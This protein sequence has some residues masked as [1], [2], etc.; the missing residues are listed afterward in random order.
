MGRAKNSPTQV[1]RRGMTVYANLAD[2]V[3]TDGQDGRSGRW[4]RRSSNPGRSTPYSVGTC[5]MYG[6]RSTSYRDPQQHG[7]SKSKSRL[8]ARPHVGGASLNLR[9]SGDV[10][11]RDNSRRQLKS[12]PPSLSASHA[13][14]RRLFF[15]T[16]CSAIRSTP[17]L[18]NYGVLL[19]TEYCLSAGISVRN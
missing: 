9:R 12:F 18:G 13:L 17:Y 1:S 5:N 14:R 2:N 4:Q 11:Q 19:S 10:S 7:E 3:W 8:Q 6:V 15:S 16:E